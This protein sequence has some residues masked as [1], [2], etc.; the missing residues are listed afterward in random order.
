MAALLARAPRSLGTTGAVL[1]A[2]AV[3]LGWATLAVVRDHHQ[4]VAFTV[5]WLAMT[6]AMMLP[7]VL[8]PMMRAAD[9]SSSRMVAFAGGFTLVWLAAGVPA[10]LLLQALAWTP[11][12]IATA[13]VAT[14]LWLLS[15]TGRRVLGSCGS[16][17]YDSTPAR[18]GVQQGLRCVSSCWPLMIAAMATGMLF[19]GAVIPLLG[20]LA[21]TAFV[22]WEKAPTTSPRAVASVGLAMVLAAGGLFV[23]AGGGGAVHHH[24]IG[25][26]RS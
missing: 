12:W 13:W 21:V 23:F 6:F 25:S 8:R 22:C 11:F 4:P 5:M 19:Q 16:I 24:E 3:V 2:S 15:P 26:S 17:A 18:F 14:G 20:L 10:Y 9:G 7:S 1:A